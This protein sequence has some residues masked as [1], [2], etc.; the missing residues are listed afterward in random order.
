[1]KRTL[2]SSVAL[3]GLVSGLSAQTIV[4]AGDITSN[5][6]WGD[7]TNPSP[8]I[9]Q[10]GVFVKGDATL[11]IL[12]GT[13]VRGQPRSDLDTAI[14]AGVPG[15][16]DITPTGRIIADGL[17]TNPIVMTTAAV[18][19]DDNG[20]ADDL[21]AD[22]TLDEWPGFIPGSSPLTAQSQ[23]N[24][25]FLDDDPVNAPLA[26]LDANGDSN[27]SYWGGL[28]IL[29][30][31]PT[32]NADIAGVGYGRTN[33]EGLSVPGFGPAETA[34]GGVNPH[35][36]SGILR[37][38][39]VR[40]AGDEIGNGNEL[41]GISLGGVGDGT[42][43]EN[44]EVYCNFDDGFEWFGG[45]VNGKNLA[46]YFAGDDVF[47]LDEGYTGTNQFLFGIMPFFSENDGD[48]FG[49]KSGDKMGEFDGDNFV[50]D[51]S[52]NDVNIRY[53]VTLPIDGSF[54]PII[55]GGAWPL[56]YPSMWNMTIFGSNSTGEF[57]PTV[58]PTSASGIV[59][60][61]GFAGEIY[62]SLLLNTGASK[63]TVT[64][65]QNDDGVQIDTDNDGVSDFDGD[66]I[67]NANNGL[68]N[69]VA[70]STANSAA[71]VAGFDQVAFDNGDALAVKLGFPGAVNRI[72]L[73]GPFAVAF[74]NGDVTFNPQG[75]AAGKLEASLKAA[76]MN[77]RPTALTA[78]SAVDPNGSQGLES[79]T[80]RGAFAP[81][82]E[83][84]WTTGWSVMNT[85][86]LLI[87]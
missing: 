13:I 26:P 47:D 2:I 80:F 72:N 11:T 21:D 20:V 58:A 24:A 74:A 3:A 86:G 77:P 78:S 19:N 71:P 6:T 41:N 8:I 37:Y 33:I 14:P 82:A 55:G 43:V 46:V 7:A 45:T 29:G 17:P 73:T 49:S 28:I 34:Y 4:P 59:F 10:G 18:D 54:N 69:A 65:Q 42:I 40:H 51:N 68:V 87:D 60:R 31:A 85:S 22:G 50:A 39:S 44:C 63:S 27:V 79:V 53:A 64:V 5:T 23:A 16:L 52:S 76:P 15:F 61:N 9:L 30:N 81:T 67:V 36:N 32:N 62:N 83:T 35:D 1:M 57:T 56:S 12:P 38:V 66:T 75:N 84:L 70:T 25:L 48:E